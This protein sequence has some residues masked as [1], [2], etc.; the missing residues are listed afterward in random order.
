MKP[1]FVVTHFNQPKECTPEAQ[2]ACERLVDHG[3]PVE[4]QTVL[5]RRINSAARILADLNQRLLA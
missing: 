2:E 4:N 5:L 1:L 3:V